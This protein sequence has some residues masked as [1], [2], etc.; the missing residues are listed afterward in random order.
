L[1][2]IPMADRWAA[3]TQYNIGSLVEFEGQL[4][5]NIQPHKSQSDWTPSVT[6]ALWSLLDRTQSHSQPESSEP[7]VF[8]PRGSGQHSSTPGHVW[9]GNNDLQRSVRNDTVTEESPEVEYRSPPG[10]CQKHEISGQMPVTDARIWLQ[11]AQAR[12]AEY[13]RCGDQAPVTWILYEGQIP[14]NAIE[15]GEEHGKPLYICRAFHEGGLQ[16]GKASS[17][18][19]VIGYNKYIHPDTYEILVGDQ[20]G[21]RWVQNLGRLDILSLGARPVEGGHESNGILFFVA[22]AR[23]QG[24][25][26]PGKVNE[27][28]DGALILFGDSETL[29]KEYAVLCY[30]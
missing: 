4:Y 15:G 26:C 6:P 12:T 17:I 27:R 13:H 24:G 23:H 19:A 8:A 10:A 18:S 25:L 1:H 2:L 11:S 3:N 20:R 7:L 29:A 5:K 16:L 21:T 22:R 30:A 28:L 9:T 14:P